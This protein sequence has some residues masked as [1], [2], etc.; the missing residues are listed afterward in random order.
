MSRLLEIRR[1]PVKSLLGEEL[2][3]VV[4]DQR[5]CSGDRLWSVRDP[6][7]K[8]G[9]GKTTR[10][11]RRM[12]GLLALRATY[13]G[14]DAPLITLPDGRTVRAGSAE[15]DRALSDHVGRP[16]VVARE[17]QVSHFDE[18]PLHL[19]T[20]ASLGT[21]AAAHGQL[22]DPRRTRA[23]L[24]VDW[25]G[26]GFP[27]HDWVGR[28][29]ALGPEVVLRIR[30]V[31]PRCVMVNAAQ[32]D[33]PTDSRL[34]RRITELS[35]GALGVVADVEQGGTLTVGAGVRLLPA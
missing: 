9:S 18:G 15:A 6:D 10:R 11:F 17:E 5:G 8:F 14:N 3:E 4:V 19:V 16:V 32:G 13:D 20:T 28:R 25:A 23:N 26:E 22:V 35:E 29:L 21:L 24:V 7:G 34:L 2:D 27:E 31:M 12:D 30:G 1:F 33:L